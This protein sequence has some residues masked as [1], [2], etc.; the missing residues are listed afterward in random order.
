MKPVFKW[1]RC[2]P[3]LAVG[4]ALFNSTPVQAKDTP[5]AVRAQSDEANSDD[6][7]DEV[8]ESPDRFRRVSSQ[9][10]VPSTTT[11]TPTSGVSDGPGIIGQAGH[12]A[13]KTFGRNQSIT[14]IEAM[15][16]ILT[17]EHFIFSDLRGFVSNGGL[18]GGNLGIGYRN[19]REDMNAWYGGSLWYDNDG[20]SGKNFQQIGL[21]FEALVSRWEL[22]SNVY[23]PVSSSQT[24]ASILGNERIVGNQLLFSRF[25]DQGKALQGVDFETGYSL[26]IQDRNWL[27]GFVGYYHFNGGP[28]GGINGFK[29]RVE[30][31]INNMVTAQVLYTHDKLY[32]N[33][34]MV[35]CSLQFPW[36]GSHP[37]SNWKQNTP[38]PFRFVER[39]YNVILD[40]GT[41][42]DNNLVAINPLTHAAYKIEQVSS[43]AAAGGNGTFANPFQTVAQ[44]QA[45]G[46]D[47]ILVQGNSVLNT[48]AV[49]AAGQQLLGDGSHQ[50]IQLDGG[51]TVQLPTQ[52]TGGATPQFANVN[53]AAVTLANNS[54]FGGFTINNNNGNAVVG[55]NVAGTTIRDVT[56]Q[57][58]A[59]DAI[60][61]TNSSGDVAIN[62]VT[63]NATTGSGISLIGGTPNLNL[64][65]SLS[66]TQGDGIFLSNLTGGSVDIHDTSIQLAGGT[67][68]RLNNVA[69]DVTVDSLT[70]SQTTGSGIAITGGTSTNKYHF[71]GTTTVK[72][73][74]GNAFNVNNTNAA[75]TVDN[76]V[77]QSSAGTP[78]VSLTSSTGA[79]TLGNLNIEGTNTVGLYGR[80]LTSLVVKNGTITTINGGAVDIQGSTIN[81]TLGQVSV[82]GGPFGIRLVQNTGTFALVG[83]SAY[84]TGGT[85]KNTTTGVILTSSGSTA[86]NWLDLTNNGTGIQSTGNNLVQF[87]TMRITGSGGYA[88]DSMNDLVM[89]IGNSTLT[90]NG[91]IGGGTIRAQANA[92]GNYQWLVQ[93]NLITDHNGTPIL[94]Q[95]QAA[96]NGASLGTTIQQNTINADHAG[97]TLV[98]INWH[99]PLS[100]KVANNALN[101]GADNMTAVAL[102]DASTTDSVNARITNNAATFTGSQGT[103]ILLSAAAGSTLQVDNNQV[104]FKGV[105]GT[106]L[107]FNLGGISSTWIY[108]NIIT[109]EAGSATGMLFD[110]VAASSRLQIEANTINL[111][112]TDLTVHR[113][114]IFTSVTPTIQFAGSV[115]N[116]INN[117]STI[118]SIPVNSSTGSIIINGALFP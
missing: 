81:T 52:V 35:G 113:G 117:A 63:I 57:N 104:D 108:S 29:T 101:A 23:L 45:A 111:L 83:N 55:T 116:V 43:G 76:L 68:L 56:F 27:R 106:G 75:V 86:L 22:R 44:A 90:N 69:T 47:I 74:S 95:T 53:G 31:V 114:I 77:A 118:F 84:A 88:L 15:P 40:R 96:G 33:N 20:T 99:G 91:T 41:T 82:D 25:V 80:S 42:M 79:I 13:F 28:S 102:V 94:M 62:N 10:T 21:S 64:S 65:G 61:L 38:S 115:S 97:A 87:N 26:P 48:G 11:R 46:A 8:V 32:G 30:G 105:G 6:D 59:G 103:G 112:S 3:V 78:A 17:D 36:G 4:V 54:V 85:I 50:T 109:D 60:R 39:N 89:M 5:S 71:G 9:R 67:G 107:H 18:F 2:L 66:A 73:P 49:L 24:Y 70:V 12:L 37:T 72:Q 110:S 1:S 92:V 34:I 19:L 7:D 16:Y 51:G 14:P 58:I 98:N 93:Q 100:V